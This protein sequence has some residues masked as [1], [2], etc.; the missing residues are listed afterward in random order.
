MI[1]RKSVMI[2][3]ACILGAGAAAAQKPA[4]D[5]LSAAFSDSTRPGR[6]EI[7]L[8]N[9]SITVAGGRGRQVVFEASSVT[10]NAVRRRENPKA[11]GLRRISANGSGIVVEEDHNEMTVQ[12]GS[13]S[14][15]VDLTVQVPVKTSLKLSCINNGGVR[16]DN[17][18][19]DLEVSSLNGPV[20]LNNVSGSVVANALN[21]G[22]TVVFSGVDPEKSMSFSSM[23]G[24]ID[25]T[26]PASVKADVR[27]KNEN[28]D[29]YTDF[30][31][32][33]VEKKEKIEENDRPR[34]GKYR[35][36]VDHSFEG[37]INGGGPEYEF[38]NFNGDIYI[39][40][41]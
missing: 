22:M 3:F 40:R 19:G 39:R 5:R 27:M 30:D 10:M 1:P 35:I 34:G 2:A 11:A 17:V 41:R 28:G 13:M 31:V 26:F 18:E 23:N 16:V 29:I 37:R 36:Q 15:A 32:Q 20:T 12:V 4:V 33:P 25:V 14:S 9:G 8:I 24:D 7:N 6:V 21:Q 38:N